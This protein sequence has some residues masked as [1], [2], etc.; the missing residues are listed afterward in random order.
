MPDYIG[1]Y[2][3]VRKSIAFFFNDNTDICISEK[4][5]HQTFLD[6]DMIYDLS[7][8]QIYVLVYLPSGH[9]LQKYQKKFSDI[10]KKSLLRSP[11]II[12]MEY[13]ASNIAASENV[14]A[15]T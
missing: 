5:F 11:A 2:G 8:I 15:S 9:G 1:I 14:I 10:F 7:K 6:I 3:I 13:F 12:S 4:F